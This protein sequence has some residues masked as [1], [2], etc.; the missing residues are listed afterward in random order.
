MTCAYCTN[1]A[2]WVVFTHTHP[3]RT[4]HVCA[5]TTHVDQARTDLTTGGTMPSVTALHRSAA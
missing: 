2:V 1:P 4:R 5:N 3:R